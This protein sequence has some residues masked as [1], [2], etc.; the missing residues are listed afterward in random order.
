[1]ESSSDD[2]VSLSD[3][4][5]SDSDLGSECEDELNIL[6][7]EPSTWEE[8]RN[9]GRDEAAKRLAEVSYHMLLSTNSVPHVDASAITSTSDALDYNSQTCMDC[10]GRATVDLGL[11]KLCLLLHRSALN[12]LK[13]PLE[14]VANDICSSESAEKLKVFWGNNIGQ[15][16]SRSLSLTASSLKCIEAR[17]GQGGKHSKLICKAS[18]CDKPNSI[19]SNFASIIPAQV[20]PKL[21]FSC[22]DVNATNQVRSGA[23]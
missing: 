4:S 10:C 2:V 14:S 9:F 1:M 13:V 5:I 3:L 19:R 20:D 6:K 23:S 22:K 18:P 17:V 7:L 12:A 8:I 11:E 16:V 15:E 21:F